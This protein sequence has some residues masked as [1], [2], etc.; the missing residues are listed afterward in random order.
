MPVGDV[1]VVEDFCDAKVADPGVH[2][3]RADIA[4]LLG[5]GDVLSDEGI[6]GA[7]DSRVES[8]VSFP[9]NRVGVGFLVVRVNSENCAVPSSPDP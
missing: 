5:T 6:L 9:E 8:P 2:H 3:G 7:G 4:H 1:Q